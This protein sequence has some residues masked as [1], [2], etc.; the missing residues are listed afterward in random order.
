MMRRSS[1]V[2][3]DDHLTLFHAK[4]LTDTVKLCA[5]TSDVHLTTKESLGKRSF[6]VNTGLGLLYP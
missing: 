6:S 1:G 2:I 5:S 4:L 3:C